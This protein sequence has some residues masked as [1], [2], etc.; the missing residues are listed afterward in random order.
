MDPLS[1]ANSPQ[2]ATL[3]SAVPGTDLAGPNVAGALVKQSSTSFALSSIT[4]FIPNGNNVAIS[5]NASVF[6]TSNATGTITG[7]DSTGSADGRIIVICTRADSGLSIGITLAHESTSSLAQNRIDYGAYANLYGPVGSIVLAPGSAAILQWIRNGS[8]NY[9]WV[10]LGT[11][12]PAVGGDIRRPLCDAAVWRASQEFYFGPNDFGATGYS[13]SQNNLAVSDTVCVFQTGCNGSGPF[14]LTGIS[15]VADSGR[16]LFVY[17]R[18][19]QPSGWILIENSASSTAGNRFFMGG[20][21]FYRIDPGSIVELQYRANGTTANN[22]WYLIGTPAT[23]YLQHIIGAPGAG[24]SPAIVAGAGAGTTPTVAVSGTDISGTITVT[25]GAL[26]TA[27]A[28][29]V[30]V[31][32]GLAWPSAPRVVLTPAN[33]ATALLGFQIYPTSATGSFAL[34]APAASSLVAAV[35]YS[36]NYIVIG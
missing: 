2:F 16:V 1:D 13:S 22:G 33:S 26:P 15:S 20:R 24:S 3:A 30:T 36:W 29:V 5:A 6:E 28:V 34:N 25:A 21:G 18:S 4:Q 10:V 19:D 35:V 7:I 11:T 32:F 12:A 9:R 14:N 17:V 27:G 8:G 31:T 23:E